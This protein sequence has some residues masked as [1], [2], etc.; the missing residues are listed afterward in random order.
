A[1]AFS[2]RFRS[3]TRPLYV[4]TTQIKRITMMARITMSAIT[5]RSPFDGCWAA[6]RPW[7]G[8][9]AV[10]GHHTAQA[11]AAAGAPTGLPLRWRRREHEPLVDVQIPAGEGLHG[12]AVGPL[13][14]GAAQAGRQRVVGQD[15]GQA[16]G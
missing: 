8:R 15:V 3:L 5:I 12:E 10:G 11:P 7:P 6:D 2:T 9:S 4:I 16:G 13:V 1:Q 14:A